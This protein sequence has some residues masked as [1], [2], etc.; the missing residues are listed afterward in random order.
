MY[1]KK[2]ETK[3]LA[4]YSYM[5]GDGDYIAVIDPMRDVEIYM[6][7]AR[8]AGMRI[9]H[10]FET[11]RNKDFIVGSMELAE[12]TGATI[13]ISEHEDLGHVYGEKIQDGFELAIGK[14]T[15]KAMHTP[16]HTLGH[17]SYV[18]YEE[19]VKEAF[20]VFTGDCLFMGDLG[21]TDFYG[22]ENLDKMTGLL[23]ESVFE[24]LLPLGEHVILCPAHG[25][26][27]A[28]GDAMDE[29]TMSSFGY[30]KAKNALLQVQSKKTFI[31]KYAKMRIKPRYF[32]HMEVLNVKGSDF[33]HN[34]VVLNTLTVDEL[35]DV[36]S[37]VLLF[38]ARTKEGFIGGH[39]PGSIYLPKGNLTAFLG[40]IYSPEVK[41]TFIIDGQIGDMED[42]YWYCKRIGF[43]NFLGYLPNG[44]EMWQKSGREIDQLEAISAKA[45]KEMAKGDDFILLDIRDDHEV[46][47]K[48]PDT[49]KVSIPFKKLNESLEKIE[50]NKT[51]YVLCGSGNR[52]TTAASYLKGNG[53]NAVVIT[54]GAEMYRNFV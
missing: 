24:K 25:A 6:H 34:E 50:P 43:D 4:H 10:I 37:D 36:K 46:E 17:M 42:I 54:G 11:H 49:N 13:Y 18:V 53:Y 12:K 51:I 44:I 38:D 33:V 20:V 26:G 14:I 45:Y 47:E 39:I 8:K 5:I 27:S 30:E 40:S 48:D 19:G 35:S 31:A 1:F 9:K 2:I 32:N 3:G 21:R 29:R 7:E 52:A 41:F 22:E 15:L 28:C 23:Y 16:G